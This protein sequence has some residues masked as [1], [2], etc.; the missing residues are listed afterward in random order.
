MLLNIIIYQ[1]AQTIDEGKG[2][3]ETWVRRG[4]AIR[5][6]QSPIWNILVLRHYRCGRVRNSAQYRER[7]QIRV[8][9]LMLN[10]QGCSR[11][12]IGDG[13]LLLSGTR[14]LPQA[15]FSLFN[16]S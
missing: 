2:R 14:I 10:A 8:C 3:P 16:D 12:V 13:K 5:H 11:L 6:R 15:D 4:S 9:A 7:P 1:A